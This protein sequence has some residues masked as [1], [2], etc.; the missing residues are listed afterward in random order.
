MWLWIRNCFE[1][2]ALTLEDIIRNKL[3]CGVINPKIQQRLLPE[4]EPSLD[5]TLKIASAMDRAKTNVCGIEDRGFWGRET[6]IQGTM[7]VR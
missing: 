2:V 7:E 3:A 6:K 4:T 5:K 1:F